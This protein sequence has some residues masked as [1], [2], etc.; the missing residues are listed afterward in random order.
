M[1]LLMNLDDV[2][3]MIST[4]YG[5]TQSESMCVQSFFFS[6]G[7][8]SRGGVVENACKQFAFI[9]KLFFVWAALTLFYFVYMVAYCSILSIEF[10]PKKWFISLRT[11]T[12]TKKQTKSDELMSCKHNP[13]YLIRQKNVT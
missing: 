6:L 10:H 1:L 13:D 12:T 2:T 4:H 9:V 5:Q 3:L 11:T 8:L 7:L